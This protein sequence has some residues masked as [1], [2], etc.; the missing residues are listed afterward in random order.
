[1][2][3]DSEFLFARPSFLEGVARIMDFTGSLNEYNTS[4]SGEQAD[5][6]ALRA[7]WT[8]V[9]KDIKKAMNDFDKENKK[10]K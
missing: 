8:A 7:D 2:Y 10:K 3:D 1:M 5:T 6:R 4:N 9:G